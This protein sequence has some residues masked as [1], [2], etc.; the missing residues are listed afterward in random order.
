MK[1]IRED[2]F[3]VLF[4]AS[5]NGR[6]L[7]GMEK[8]FCTGPIN[9]VIRVTRNFHRFP[10]KNSNAVVIVKGIKSLHQSLGK[11]PSFATVKK[12]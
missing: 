5:G 4:N 8:V 10:T 1:D 2:V 7:D 3:A 11:C 6:K 9:N 12:N